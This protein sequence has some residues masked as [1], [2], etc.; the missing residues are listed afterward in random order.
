MDNNVQ[1]V[2]FEYLKNIIYNPE[3]ASI[4]V[5][6]LPEDFRQLGAGME[7]LGKCLRENKELA[8][9]LSKGDLN[10]QPP[11]AENIIAAPLKEIQANL[12]H[13]TWQAGQ[14]AKGDYGQNFIIWEIFQ[15]PLIL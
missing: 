13:I 11:N 15:K 10:V 1:D 7:F 6:E 3:K 14:V 8:I 5:E 2:L 12:L 9:S 4:N